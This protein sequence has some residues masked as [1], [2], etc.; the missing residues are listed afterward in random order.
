MKCFNCD[1]TLI[2]HRSWEVTNYKCLLLQCPTCQADIA[3]KVPAHNYQG[4]H[5]EE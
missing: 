5:E 1:S 4:I 2:L 3:I